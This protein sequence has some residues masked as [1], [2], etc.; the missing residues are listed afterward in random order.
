M[1]NVLII[2]GLK[3]SYFKTKFLYT[4]NLNGVFQKPTFTKYH[5]TDLKHE[6]K[7]IKLKTSLV[8]PTLFSNFHFKNSLA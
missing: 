5:A 3:S 2:F 1:K 4:Y 6:D 8:N 7:F